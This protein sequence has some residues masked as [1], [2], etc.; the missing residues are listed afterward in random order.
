MTTTI[1]ITGATGFVGRHLAERAVAQ[2]NAVRALTR[3]PQPAQPGIVWIEGALD[4]P[5]SLGR[6]V[7]GADAVIH[8]AGVINAR[9]EAGFIAG[10]VAGT[11]SMIAAAAAA[12]V[13]RFVH[14]SSLAAREPE[15]S[16]YGRSKAESEKLMAESGLDW[17]IVR[18]PAVYGPGDRES[19]ELFRMAARGLVLLPPAGRLSLIHAHDLADLLLLLAGPGAPSHLTLE[20]DDNRPGGWGHHEFATAIADAVGRKARSL[21]M[22]APLLTL[23]AAIDTGWARLNRRLPKLSFDRARY[24]CHPDWVATA[25]RRPDAA[26]WSPAIETPAGLA[27][28]AAW[29]REKGWL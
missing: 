6:L 9:N 21:P 8:V 18:P 4:L 7:E 28:V 14:V 5:G 22:P 1:A 15:L 20:P 2:G 12:D 3:R 27:A 13:R 23:G 29:Y 16:A 17:A 10:N 26:F 25:E 19:L 11:A 24:F